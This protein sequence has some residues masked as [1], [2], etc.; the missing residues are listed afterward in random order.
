MSFSF[1]ET[2]CLLI[3]NMILE[4][5]SVNHNLHSKLALLKKTN[6]DLIYKANMHHFKEVFRAL[7]SL[8]TNAGG[9]T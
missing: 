9:E 2:S 7:Y 8:K 5:L 3:H 4:F 6:A 1:N